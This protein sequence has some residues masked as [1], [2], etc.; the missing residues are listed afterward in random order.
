MKQ[1]LLMARKKE[2]KSIKPRGNQ[3]PRTVFI[4][5]WLDIKHSTLSHNLLFWII[6]NSWIFNHQNL[7]GTLTL[8]RRGA[9]KNWAEASR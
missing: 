2:S 7:I 3:G 4:K 6:E 5:L 8:C 1:N 9:E